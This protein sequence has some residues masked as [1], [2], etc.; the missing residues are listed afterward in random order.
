MHHSVI[1]L[2]FGFVSHFYQVAEQETPAAPHD[3][4]GNQQPDHLTKPVS[5]LGKNPMPPLY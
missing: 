1:P 4:S 5:A 2:H 3:G